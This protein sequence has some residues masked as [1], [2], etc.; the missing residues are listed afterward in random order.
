MLNYINKNG[1][2]ESVK[3]YSE[4]ELN[5]IGVYGPFLK[6]NNGNGTRCC[7]LGDNS[8][9]VI[10]N[11]HVMPN[12]GKLIS[13]II[14]NNISL[15]LNPD[16]MYN[17]TL[18][19][20]NGSNVE[21]CIYRRTTT[22]NS[23]GVSST[24]TE[25]I[26]SANGGAGGAGVYLSLIDINGKQKYV[27]IGGGGG[28]RGSDGA[29]RY[30][31]GLGGKVAFSINNIK[32]LD[33][34]V[35]QG[36]NGGRG[37]SWKLDPDPGAGGGGGLGGRGGRAA[38]HVHCREGGG[39]EPAV[40]HRVQPGALGR[41]LSGT[42]ARRVE[43]RVRLERYGKE[44]VCGQGPEVFFAPRRGRVPHRGRRV[45]RG[46]QV[47]HHR[48]HHGRTLRGGHRYPWRQRPGG[49]GAEG[50]ARGHSRARK[51]EAFG[52]ALPRRES[53]Y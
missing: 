40:G 34:Y 7:V 17:F 46:R 36:G 5:N 13:S 49:Q 38:G 19:S 37:S 43:Q 35:L 10:N 32:H 30:R 20:K 41:L 52:Q 12:T 18:Y 22:T 6:F 50:D 4:K 33:F 23:Y 9:L 26:S 2:K 39:V 25:L 28:G 27:A 44:A 1:I 3:D 51:G 47:A 48:S 42:T 14:N 21:V 16:I 29:G 11:K 8:N 53:K 24:H 31:G 45:R 15:D